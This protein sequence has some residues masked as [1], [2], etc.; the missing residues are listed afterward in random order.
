MFF[1]KKDIEKQKLLLSQA[2]VEV[3]NI[4]DLVDDDAFPQEAQKLLK[5]ESDEAMNILSNPNSPLENEQLRR[6][7]E[8][9]KNKGRI[10]L[11]IK[12]PQEK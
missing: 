11:D 1:L 7:A 2:Q 4:S 8:T 5:P 6:E 10:E 3:N 12:V 9:Q